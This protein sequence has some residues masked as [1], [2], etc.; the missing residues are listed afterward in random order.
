MFAELNDFDITLYDSGSI[1]GSAPSLLMQRLLNS[2]IEMDLPEEDAFSELTLRFLVDALVAINLLPLNER[3]WANGILSL[4][5]S[6]KAFSLKSIPL[7]GGSSAMVFDSVAVIH[8]GA[9][10]ASI[11]TYALLD[12]LN[13][14]SA[15]NTS[16][17]TW[18][19]D[20][21]D[22][23]EVTDH[24]LAY[25]SGFQASLRN[26]N[27]LLLWLRKDALASELKPSF[28]KK[29]NLMKKGD[30]IVSRPIAADSTGL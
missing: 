10:S 15:S 2:L 9:V 1:D 22:V 8:L 24:L 21:S 19:F 29:F 27:L 26:G 4:I 25:L 16:I 7:G 28:T 13:N 6:G 30:F 18:I 23:M 14:L 3:G 12:A 5:N 20:F 17:T 11:G